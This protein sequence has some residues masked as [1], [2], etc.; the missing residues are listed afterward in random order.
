MALKGSLRDFPPP[1]LLNLIQLSRKTGLLTIEAVESARLF[2]REGQLIYGSRGQDKGLADIL[3]SR[4]LTAGQSRLVEAY[5]S[6]GDKELAHHLIQAGLT[7]QRELVDHIEQTLR[8][9]VYQSFRWQ[10]G[11]FIFEANEFP[12][13]ESITVFLNLEDVILEGKRQLE[14]WERLQQAIP[15]LDVSFRFAGRP[16]DQLKHLHFSRD[17][18]RVLS[19]IDPRNTLRQIAETNQLGELEIR[20]TVYDLLQ[21]GVIEPV[22]DVASRGREPAESEVGL[23]NG[24]RRSL[25]ARFRDRWRR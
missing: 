25:L 20:R 6:S 2:F 8:Q 7:S 1:Q 17:E 14:E 9:L 3:R 12:S 5:A 19:F 15:T 16:R 10:E 21:A 22:E 4:G 11:N 23:P 24:D 13:P 18:W